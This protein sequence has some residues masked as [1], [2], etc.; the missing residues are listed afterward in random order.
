MDTDKAGQLIEQL[1]S[2]VSGLKEALEPL[3]TGDLNETASKLPVLDRAKLYIFVTY[4]I[5]SILFCTCQ[6]LFYSS[7]DS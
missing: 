1:A 2:N 3:L 6:S 4:T 7:F 5:E